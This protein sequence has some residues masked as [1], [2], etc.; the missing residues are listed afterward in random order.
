V[1]LRKEESRKTAEALGS[2]YTAVNLLRLRFENLAGLLLGDAAR[3]G[4]TLSG[5]SL[6]MRAW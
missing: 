3:G 2:Q 4:A 1:K 6:V 5:Y